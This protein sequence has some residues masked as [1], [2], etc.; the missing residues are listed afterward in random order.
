MHVKIC[1]SRLCM[2]MSSFLFVRAWAMPRTLYVSCGI[3]FLV[4]TCDKI[5]RFTSNLAQIN[6][7]QHSLI[8]SQSLMDSRNGIS[9]RDKG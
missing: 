5:S 9:D 3:P 6:I 8:L 7:P 1:P 4:L 2:K